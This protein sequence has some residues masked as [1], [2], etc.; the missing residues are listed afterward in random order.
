MNYTDDNNT[1]SLHLVMLSPSTSGSNIP[2]LGTIDTR[3][4][5]FVNRS[6]DDVMGK[7]QAYACASASV[8]GIKPRTYT[9]MTPESYY[10]TAPDDSVVLSD[11]DGER[12]MVLRFDLV[13]GIENPTEV[14]AE[15]G[16]SLAERVGVKLSETLFSG[17]YRQDYP[18][19]YD[20]LKSLGFPADYLDVNAVMA[21]PPRQLVTS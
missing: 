5:F 19:A 11:E 4:Y 6:I 10:E 12:G 15:L 21:L 20:E 9:V 7:P 3:L 16:K 2:V 18:L 14:I 1:S 8:P 13:P 17:Q